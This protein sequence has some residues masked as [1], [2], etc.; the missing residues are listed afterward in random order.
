MKFIF[1][2]YENTREGMGPERVTKGIISVSVTF[3]SQTG[4]CRT[5]GIQ[6][7]RDLQDF[8]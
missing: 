3:L 6:R 7:E 8:Y 2:A 4:F 5:V 1:V